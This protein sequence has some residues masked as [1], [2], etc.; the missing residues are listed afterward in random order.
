MVDFKKELDFAYQLVLGRDC[1]P[2]GYEIYNDLL[3]KGWVDLAGVIEVLMHSD[4][5]ARPDPVPS[6]PS[7]E[8]VALE[9]V[10]G[11]ISKIQIGLRIWAGVRDPRYVATHCT[12]KAEKM[13]GV[14]PAE[15]LDFADE[16]DGMIHDGV[17]LIHRLPQPH[18]IHKGRSRVRKGEVDAFF[19]WMDV[20]NETADSWRKMIQGQPGAGSSYDSIAGWCEYQHRN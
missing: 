18:R 10:P 7:T 2:S 6:E 9:R 8:Y 13:F 16:Y 5:R 20:M 11:D 4:E 1:D 3:D 12:S 19:E 17:N 15:M 14:S